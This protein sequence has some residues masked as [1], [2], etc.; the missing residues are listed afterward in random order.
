MFSVTQMKLM[1]TKWK[2]LGERKKYARGRHAGKKLLLAAGEINNGGHFR[3]KSI[4][5]QKKTRTFSTSLIPGRNS[6]D[7]QTD[8]SLSH[9]VSINHFSKLLAR[10]KRERVRV[11]CI[12]D[13]CAKNAYIF[14]NRPQLEGG[15]SAK[16]TKAVLKNV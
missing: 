14:F 16:Q 8:R 11:A 7:R 13:E 6:A 2:L 3:G 9:L 10:Q 5:C 12:F 1:T 15:E 4:F